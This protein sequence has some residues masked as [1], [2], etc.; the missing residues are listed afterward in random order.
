MNQEPTNADIIEV[1][2]AFS[3]KIDGRMDKL[4]GRMDKL[5]GRMDKLEK[6]VGY[7]K[8]NMVTK[9]DL[10]RALAKQNGDL[11]LTMRKEDAKLLELTSILKDK[12][13]LT[14]IEVKRVVSMEPFA[15][16]SV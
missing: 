5:D 15:Q 1:V 10:D 8:S 9:D 2:N 11:I 13:V 12:K 14:P 16:L 6:D 3:T 4:D 7:L